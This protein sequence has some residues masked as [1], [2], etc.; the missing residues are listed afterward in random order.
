MWRWYLKDVT[1]GLASILGGL[2]LRWFSLS[3]ERLGT[4][5]LWS[6]LFLPSWC[7]FCSL[8]PLG[9]WSLFSQDAIFHLSLESFPA[10]TLTCLFFLFFFFWLQSS[11][12]LHPLK[13]TLSSAPLL[14]NPVLIPA[15]FS[16][17]SVGSSAFF[18][19]YNP[20]HAAQC[21]PVNQL[22]VWII[23]LSP[24]CLCS[25]LSELFKLSDPPVHWQKWAGKGCCAFGT[26]RSK[27][28]VLA[29]GW[30]SWPLI[31]SKPPNR[32]TFSLPQRPGVLN[33]QLRGQISL[34][35]STCR[36]TWMFFFSVKHQMC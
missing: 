27:L 32:P 21:F 12:L 36:Q 5:Q 23:L 20:V 16:P 18:P 6:L 1:D 9:L 15:I 13:L 3:P 34:V 30:L 7:Q 14:S 17:L 35:H 26:Q 29:E 28:K 11:L 2:L 10:S 4:C 22:P 19:P 8:F 31:P 24:A 25:C 33:G